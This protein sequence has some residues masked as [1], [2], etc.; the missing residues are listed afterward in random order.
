VRVR[1]IR[2]SID[3]DEYE[4][5]RVVVVHNDIEASDPRF[6]DA[7][8]SVIEGRGDELFDTFGFDAHVNMKDEEWCRHTETLAPNHALHE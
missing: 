3:L 5:S 6:L 1:G 7:R 4:P 2:G 8:A